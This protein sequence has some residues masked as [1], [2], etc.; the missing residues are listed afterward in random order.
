MEKD[1][2]EAVVTG[3]NA[4]QSEVAVE[5]LQVPYD[6]FADKIT[7]AI[8]RGKGPDVF[9]FAQD[10]IG[11]WAE[12]S[13]IEPIGFWVTDDIQK[14]FSPSTIDALTY[15]DALYGLPTAFKC[16]V[17]FYNKQMVSEAPKT[18]DE[19]IAL[20]QKF[21]DKDKGTFGLVYENGLLYYNSVWMNAFGGGIFDKN[22][23]P[24]LD[25]EANVNA[26]QFAYDLL[27][28]HKIM[29]EEI[30]NTLVT[31]L[32]NE[33][34]AAMV[35]S[36]PWFSGEI[37]QGM[38]YGVAIHPTVV[39]TG[40]P[41]KPFLTVEGAL[42]SAKSEHKKEAYQFIEFLTNK[43]SSTIMAVQ[44]KQPVANQAAFDDPRVASDPYLPVFKAQLEN[45][46]PM[47]NFPE[48]RMVWTPMDI[49][50]GKVLNDSATAADALKE[51]QEKILKDVKRFQG[52]E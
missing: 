19:L 13:I 44:G 12:S 23:L 22:R 39:G 34:K 29:P 8:P 5:M 45:A 52:L 50:I 7:A 43:E 41:G 36:G 6:A 2:L 30:S 25:S 47:P 35:I 16:T 33:G 9:I 31:T 48:M 46:V 18:T 24:V 40:T 20:G 15:E 26:I 11:D 1:A 37:R 14:R 38:E 49:A 4:S 10:R 3:F 51:A 42:L 28:K 21:T 27:R 32:F 17:L